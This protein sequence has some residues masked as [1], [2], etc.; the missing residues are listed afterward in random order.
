MN[1]PVKELISITTLATLTATFL[2]P[3][4]LWA[5]YEVL[6]VKPLTNAVEAN[7]AQMSKNSVLAI[8]RDEKAN[9]RH[10]Q[11][12]GLIYA[13]NTRM[14]M[15]EVKLKRVIHDCEVNLEKCEDK[16]DE[17]NHK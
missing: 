17:H 16:L 10:D 14:G 7:T 12:M 15:N 13:Q 6:D 5:F 4:L 9:K 11:M 1:R 2:A 8:K 3:I